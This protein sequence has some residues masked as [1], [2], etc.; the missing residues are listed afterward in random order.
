LFGQ[1]FGQDHV[2]V[3]TYGNVLVGIAFLTGMAQEELTRAELSA[4]DPYFP[5]IIAVRAVKA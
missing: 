3:R 4:R 1:A 2:E 5:L